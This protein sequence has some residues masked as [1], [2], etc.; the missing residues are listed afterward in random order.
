MYILILP[1]FGMVSEVIPV[2][3]RKVIFGYEF[4][5]AATMAIAFISFGVWPITCSPWA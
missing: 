1:A 2:F 5:A 3:S 4:V